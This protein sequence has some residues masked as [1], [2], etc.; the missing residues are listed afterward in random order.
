MDRS[1]IF[2]RIL[3][4]N[5]LRRAAQLPALPVRETYEREVRAAR[6]REIIEKHYRDVRADVA[7]QLRAR[8]G[9][10]HGNSAGGR[11]SVELLTRKALKERYFREP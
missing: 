5:R 10:D 11:W 8:H 1:A 3:E 2:S 4:R 6:W 9:P 7:Q